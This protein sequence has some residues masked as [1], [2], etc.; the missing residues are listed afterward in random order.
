MSCSWDE[1][2]ARQSE[3]D[4]RYDGYKGYGRRE[5]VPLA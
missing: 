4:V 3:A 5:L 1:V 2:A